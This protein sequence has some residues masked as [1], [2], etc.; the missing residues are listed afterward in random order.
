LIRLFIQPRT[1]YPPSSSDPIHVF[2]NGD[3]AGYGLYLTYEPGVGKPPPPTYKLFFTD[4]VTNDII[5]VSDSLS[6]LS[7]NTWYHFGIRFET[8]GDGVDTP[9]VTKVSAFQNGISTVVNQGFPSGFI[10][11]PTG[12]CTFYARGT[13]L[14]GYSYYGKI[15][16]FAFLEAQ[17]SDSQI[18][19][20][21]TAGYV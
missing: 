7:E 8:T 1:T 18:T 5:Q 3:T 14:V 15:T 13:L 9:F 19:N 20:I 10:Q 16:D 12:F 2:Y 17:L 21:A 6:V 11:Q 4:T